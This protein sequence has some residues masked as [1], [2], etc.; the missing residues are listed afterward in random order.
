MA[1]GD[2]NGHTQTATSHGSGRA[3]NI[4]VTDS[5]PNRIFLWLAFMGL[6]VAI[7][8]I[9]ILP[10]IGHRHSEPF[11]HPVNVAVPA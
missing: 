4:V 7:L 6:V 2:E 9:L 11:S 10:A 5:G 3:T 1:D 8:I